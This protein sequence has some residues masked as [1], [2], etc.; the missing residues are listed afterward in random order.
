MPAKASSSVE[1]AYFPIKEEVPIRTLEEELPLDL[2][3]T[4]MTKQPSMTSSDWERNGFS[5]Q[6]PD[7]WG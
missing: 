4:M 1:D 6:L 5:P 3:G 7:P 2:A